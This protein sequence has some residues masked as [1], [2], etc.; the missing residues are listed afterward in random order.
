MRIRR[1][2]VGALL[3]LPT[4]AFA[5]QSITLGEAVRI[6]LEKNPLR[7]AAMADT[8]ATAASVREARAGLLPHLMF[9]ETAVR[10][11]DPVFVFGTKLRQQRF[12]AADFALNQLNTPTPIGDFSSKF[13]G[14]WRLFDSL[15]N[16]RTIERARKLNDASR[17]QL[18]RADQE[19]ISRVVESYYG[20]LLA[21]RRVSVAE[22]ASKTAKSIE[23]HSRNRVQAGLAVDADL[24]SAQVLTASR[25]QELIRA[26]NDLSYAAVALAITLGLSTEA[27]PLPADVLADRELPS[28]DISSLETEALQKRPDLRRVRNEQS[29]QQ[30]SVGIAKSAFGPRL[31]AFGSW[32]TDSP[33][34]G[35]NGG[36]NWT[37]GVELQFDLFSG[38]AKTAQLQRERANSD[39]IAA[40]R[41][42]F[43]D[44]VRLQVRRAYYDHDS[45]RQQVAVAKAASEQSAESLRI[46]RNRYDAGLATVTDLLRVEEAAHRAQSDYWDAVYRTQTSFANLQL[47]A[48]TLTPDSAVVKP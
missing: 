11:N 10:S 15:Q 23:E 36:N 40:M 12:S 14:Q 21:Q 33:S 2:I 46:L 18:E 39:R 6:A 3:L 41:S 30:Q 43:E 27:T 37:A 48:G 7:K 26:R 29:A 47:A 38:G 8:R 20:V 44:Q 28:S 5:Q 17:D 31:N 16:Y 9:S 13:S 25:E 24:L 45:A 22:D 4:L 32:Q 35:W 42:A 34:P 1:L 19:L